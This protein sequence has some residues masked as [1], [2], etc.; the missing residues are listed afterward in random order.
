MYVRDVALFLKVGGWGGCSRESQ[1]LCPLSEIK[2]NQNILK[3]C[4]RKKKPHNNFESIIQNEFL[5]YFRSITDN[6]ISR[7]RSWVT[8]VV[9]CIHQLAMQRKIS[10]GPQLALMKRH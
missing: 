3:P 8:G 5:H 1:T 4:L 7:F 6:N 10:P 2:K 9:S